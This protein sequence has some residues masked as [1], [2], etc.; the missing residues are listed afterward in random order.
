MT[1]PAT[2]PPCQAACSLCGSSPRACY[3]ASAKA[4]GSKMRQKRECVMR[5]AA[6]LV[7]EACSQLPVD[8]FALHHALQYVRLSPPWVRGALWRYGNGT[9][10][11]IHRT[12]ER[13][14][15]SFSGACK[16]PRI[17]HTFLCLCCGVCKRAG[18]SKEKIGL[19][20]FKKGPRNFKICPTFFSPPPNPHE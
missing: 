10:Y 3:H 14:E 13:R 1:K 15:Y 7:F 18:R 5:E 17:F 4:S 9:F 19:R 2:C 6:R 12:R 8:A 20:K 16:T 11:D